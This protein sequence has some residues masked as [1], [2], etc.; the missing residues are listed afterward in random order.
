[1][2]LNPN[3]PPWLACVTNIFLVPT[4]SMKNIKAVKS[5][6]WCKHART[7]YSISCDQGLCSIGM[8]VVIHL[9]MHPC[10]ILITIKRNA[11]L[12]K[13]IKDIGARKWRDVKRSPKSGNPSLTPAGAL[14]A[15]ICEF[16]AV[17]SLCIYIHIYIYSN[18]TQITFPDAEATSQTTTRFVSCNENKRR[19]VVNVQ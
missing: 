16:L 12:A 14:Y 5:P 10:S 13:E 4:Q 17:S 15:I 6:H 18:R 1:M 9:F 2:A 8:V 3:V 19:R 7:I 11:I